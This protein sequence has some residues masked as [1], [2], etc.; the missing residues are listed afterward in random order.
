MISNHILWV[1]GAAIWVG[2]PGSRLLA[3]HL[4]W[5][6]GVATGLHSLTHTSC[7]NRPPCVLTLGELDFFFFLSYT[8]FLRADSHTEISFTKMQ[9]HLVCLGVTQDSKTSSPLMPSQG[10]GRM[11]AGTGVTHFCIC[12]LCPLPS[13]L[14]PLS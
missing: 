6:H 9:C 13:P 8:N 3:Y 12:F 2:R 4:L 11:L 5:K 14:Q 1:V 10:W 7:F